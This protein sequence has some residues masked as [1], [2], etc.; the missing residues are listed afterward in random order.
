MDPKSLPRMCFVSA[1]GRS[2]NCDQ[3][4]QKLRLLII[5]MS[6]QTAR[7][8][9]GE[10][11]ALTIFIAAI[12]MGLSAMIY[13]YLQDIY[14]LIYY[15][16][17]TSHLFSAKRFVDSVEPGINQIGSVWLPL[18]HWMFLPFTL[19]EQLYSNGMA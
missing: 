8:F 10:R 7:S 13:L 14:S 11:Q 18:P 5:I 12:A 15:G 9:F 4:Y 17:S 19:I 3:I 1:V 16:D 2:D 6:L